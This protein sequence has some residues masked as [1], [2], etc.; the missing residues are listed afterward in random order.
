VC[1]NVP[2]HTVRPYKATLEWLGEWL[3]A[4][5]F[6]EGNG[7]PALAIATGRSYSCIFLANGCIGLL[8]RIARQMLPR[9]CGIPME[10]RW[11]TTLPSSVQS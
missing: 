3:S 6:A 10:P 8:I 2:Y 5:R 4:S 7:H 11:Q 9:L 1:D